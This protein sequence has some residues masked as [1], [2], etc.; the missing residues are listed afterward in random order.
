MCKLYLLHLLSTNIVT[1]GND[2]PTLFLE[3]IKVINHQRAKEGLAILDGRLV[4]YHLC[5]FG[6]DRFHNAL[7]GT[8]AEVV[9]VTFHREAIDPNDTFLLTVGI[10]LATGF[11]IARLAEYLLCNEVLTGGI[12][13]DNGFYQIF[14]HISIVGKELF[15]ILGKAVAAIAKAGIIIV[16]LYMIQ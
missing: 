11:V 12:A 14:R 6:L 4:D 8:L 16:G 5:T 13:G 10:P 1:V 3:L 9:A 15:S 7:N 2:G